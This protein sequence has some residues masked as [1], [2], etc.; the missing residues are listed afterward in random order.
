MCRTC[1]AATPPGRR[2]GMQKP[3]LRCYARAGRPRLSP[4]SWP[5]SSSRPAMTWWRRSTGWGKQPGSSLTNSCGDCPRSAGFS[6]LS[7]LFYFFML[8]SPSHSLSEIQVALIPLVWFSA[9]SL[10][11]QNLLTKH[12]L[13]HTRDC[14][15]ACISSFLQHHFILIFLARIV[16]LQVCYSCSLNIFIKGMNIWYDAEKLKK[17]VI[18]ISFFYHDRSHAPRVPS[19]FTPTRAGSGTLLPLAGSRSMASR[20]YLAI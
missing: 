14:H 16:C 5:A 11:V 19:T 13:L 2:R 15:F 1:T 18:I 10:H 9:F 7:V 6:C 17:A 4:N 8:I 12:C 20:C 3:P